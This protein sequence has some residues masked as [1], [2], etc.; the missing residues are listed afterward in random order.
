MSDEKS[1]NVAGMPDAP[2]ERDA[3][4]VLNDA[5]AEVRQAQSDDRVREHAAAI[6]TELL[7]RRAERRAV[8]QDEQFE[9]AK[10][11][12]AAA[13][14]FETFFENTIAESP[15]ERRVDLERWRSSVSPIEGGRAV[16]EAEDGIGV[17]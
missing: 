11:A 17:L 15:S 5:L 16:P 14:N 1:F 8:D 9:L 6:Y 3:A 7:V 13:W 4:R 10:Q 12:F 2:P